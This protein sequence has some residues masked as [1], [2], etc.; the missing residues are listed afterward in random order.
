MRFASLAKAEL[1]VG[2]PL[3]ARARL[4]RLQSD[5]SRKMF[6]LIVRQ[7]SASLPAAH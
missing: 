2:R 5:A 7:A 6:L 1:R 3:A 4:D